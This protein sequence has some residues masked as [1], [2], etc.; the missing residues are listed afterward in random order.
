MTTD[1]SIRY[2]PSGLSTGNFVGA[3]AFGM[4]VGAAVL[5]LIV[6][7]DTFWTKRFM[8][9]ISAFPVIFYGFHFAWL[10]VR[11]MSSAKKTEDSSLSLP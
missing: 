5:W 2:S 3:T 8:F 7:T 1:E 9:G 6:G 4:C 11:Q 10:K